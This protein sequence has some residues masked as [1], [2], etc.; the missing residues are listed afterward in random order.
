MNSV[1]AFDPVANRKEFPLIA[2][3]AD[4]DQIV[5]LDNA[6]TTQKPES[7][8]AALTHYYSNFNANV[9]RGVHTLSDEATLAFEDARQTVAEFV[10]AESVQEIIWTRG[11]TESIN[12]V[13][14]CC[15][16]M[17]LGDKRCDLGHR[18]GTPFE[19]RSMADAS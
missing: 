3:R 15:G 16:F 19:H 10:N 9:H 2:G 8:L 14:A 6:A 1:Q 18:N 12:L 17:Q 5:Y 7:V 4:R 13:A 11:T